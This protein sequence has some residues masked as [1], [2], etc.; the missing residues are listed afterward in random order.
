MEDTQ[1]LKGILEGCVL[2]I[3]GRGETYGYEIKEKL[4][5]FG[6]TDI[7]D[8]TLYPVLNR[9]EKKELIH[10]HAGESEIGPQRKYISI[11]KEGI[12]HLK[13]FKSVYL[14][15]ISTTNNILFMEENYE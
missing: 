8:G 7:L 4:S 5:D 6:F 11:T 1:L 13:Q 14:K 12:S 2:A 3:V 10:V 15:T 9:L